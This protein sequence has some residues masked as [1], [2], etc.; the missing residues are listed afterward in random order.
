MDTLGAAGVML[1]VLA[2]PLILR[3]VP[4]NRLYGLRV[5]ATRADRW[6]WYEANAKSARDMLLLGLLLVVL[7]L[8]VS[9]MPP[10]SERAQIGILVVGVIA[11]GVVGWRRANQLLELHM[12][13]GGPRES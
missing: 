4:P 10:V 1:I 13:Q 7:G 5:P 9:G 3:L 6:V 12:K 2:A 11:I 8:G